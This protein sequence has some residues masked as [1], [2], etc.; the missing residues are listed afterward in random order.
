MSAPEEAGSTAVS[1]RA[2]ISEALLD[3]SHDAEAHAVLPLDCILPNLRQ[4]LLRTDLEMWMM[5]QIPALFGVGDSEEL[6]EALQEEGQ[7]KIIEGLVFEKD[8]AR[9]R[10]I[11]EEYLVSSPELSLR[12]S[13]IKET[14]AKIREIIDAGNEDEK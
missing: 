7:S 6:D 10:I 3:G 12:D 9:R 5:D 1:R 8:E 14:L 2:S 13:L 11:L 4:H